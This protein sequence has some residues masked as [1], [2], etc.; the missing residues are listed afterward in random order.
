ML[1]L[2]IER[3]DS[4]RALRAW[5]ILVRCKEFDW[6]VMWRTGLHI[7]AMRQNR[8]NDDAD[9]PF[10]QCLDLARGMMLKQPDDVSGRIDAT[11]W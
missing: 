6:K 7:I 4:D 2:S 10:R 1:H 8:E 11:T 9:R 5:A 3:H